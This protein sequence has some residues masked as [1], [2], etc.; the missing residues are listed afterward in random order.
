MA[1]KFRSKY[2]ELSDAEKQGLEA[3]KSAASAYHDALQQHGAP[4]RELSLAITKIEESV[5]WA[6]KGITG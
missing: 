5:M 6:V 3:I 2:R 1:D 4:G